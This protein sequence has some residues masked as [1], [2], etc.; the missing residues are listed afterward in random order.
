ME[1][2]VTNLN[3]HLVLILVLGLSNKTLQSWNLLTTRL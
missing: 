2:I 3:E 1:L